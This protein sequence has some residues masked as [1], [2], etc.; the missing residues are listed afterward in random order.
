MGLGGTWH[1]GSGG[2][3]ERCS[4]AESV[5]HSGGKKWVIYFIFLVKCY[6]E[7]LNDKMNKKIKKYF[8]V[9]LIFLYL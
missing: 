7:V 2:R 5:W 4:V 8:N 1:T 9:I 6:F 3:E